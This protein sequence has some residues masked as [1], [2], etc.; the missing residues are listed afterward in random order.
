MKMEIHN[1]CDEPPAD[2]R[3]GVELPY[4][5]TRCILRTGLAASML[6]GAGLG[7]SPAFFTSFGGYHPQERRTRT[8]AHERARDPEQALVG[9][10]PRDPA[11][12]S[13]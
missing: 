8:E 5:L 1:P 11:V 13:R 4:S 3:G 7:V 2:L 10:G 6:V 9:D 12:L